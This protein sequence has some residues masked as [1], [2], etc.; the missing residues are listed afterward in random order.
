MHTSSTP[1]TGNNG[2][3]NP[4]PPAGYIY[5]Q[6]TDNYNRLF[7]VTAGWVSP[8]SG[9]P[10]TSVSANTVYV[11]VTVGTGTQAQWQAIGLPAGVAPAIGATFVAS[12]STTVPGSGAVEVI[13]STGAGIDHLEGVGDANQTLAPMPVGPSPNVGGWIMLSSWFE[14]A[15]TAPANNTVMGL[16]L[17]LSYSSVKVAGE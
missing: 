9:T 16:K 3:L 11:I 14:G 10:L 1:G 17:Y 8:L 13:S 12:Q 15:V 4:N 5:V 2:Q 6:T 7:S